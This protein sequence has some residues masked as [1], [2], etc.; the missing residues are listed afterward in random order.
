L[1][2]KDLKELERLFK[3]CRKQGITEFSAE[4]IAIKFG[5]LPK[6]ASE[7]QTDSDEIESDNPYSN[8][9]DGIL[10][11]DQLMFYSAGGKPEDDPVLHG[12]KAS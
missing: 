9:P 11:P 6:R 4:G 7:V 8:F 10:T 2:V 12:G 3:L 1:I 5:E